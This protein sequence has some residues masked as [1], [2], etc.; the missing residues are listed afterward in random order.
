MPPKPSISGDGR[1]VAFTSAP[2]R[3]SGRSSVMV[4][5]LKTGRT[6][7]VSEPGRGGAAGGGESYEPAISYNGRYVAFTSTVPDLGGGAARDAHAY[8][9]AIATAK[10]PCL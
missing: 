6:E 3:G 4:R 2:R 9:C 7:V 5:D 8:S 10:R 1:F